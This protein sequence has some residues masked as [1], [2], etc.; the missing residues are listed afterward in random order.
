MKRSD[1]S[2]RTR[3]RISRKRQVGSSE[4]HSAL[5]VNGRNG[6]RDKGGSSKVLEHLEEGGRAM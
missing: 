6:K 1:D 3:T 5:Y 2:Q 4:W